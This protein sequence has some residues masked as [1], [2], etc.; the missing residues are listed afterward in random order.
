MGHAGCMRAKHLA[1]PLIAILAI[2]ITTGPVRADDGEV[3]GS[4]SGGPS[5]FRLRVQPGVGDSLRVR[6]E[7]EGNEPGERWQLFM[8]DDGRRIFARTRVSDDE[9]RVR[10]RKATDDRP[11][12]DRIS[13]TGVNLDTGESCAGSVSF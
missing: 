9:G 6:F 12:R 10:V 8:S 13:A 4:C 2:A 1:L 11:G 7:I 3:H 5:E